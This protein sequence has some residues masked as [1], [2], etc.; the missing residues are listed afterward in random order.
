MDITKDPDLGFKVCHMRTRGFRVQ[1]YAKD[2]PSYV[3]RNGA[4]TTRKV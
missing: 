2:A 1:G 3:T 4:R